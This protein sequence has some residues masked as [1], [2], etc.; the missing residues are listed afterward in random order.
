MNTGYCLVLIDCHHI[1]SPYSC[2]LNFASQGISSFFQDLKLTYN[3]LSEICHLA[4]Q[5]VTISSNQIKLYHGFYQSST[6]LSLRKTCSTMYTSE[7]LIMNKTFE[8]FFTIAMKLPYFLV[9]S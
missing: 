1:I 3:M 4:N 7:N 5:S 6:H 8:L 2:C 9:L